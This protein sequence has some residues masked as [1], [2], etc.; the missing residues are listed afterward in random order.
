MFSDVDVTLLSMGG[1]QLRQKLPTT[2]VM[3][4]C[5][6]MLML[7]LAITRLAFFLP[8][9][10]LVKVTLQATIQQLQAQM[11]D[12]EVKPSRILGNARFE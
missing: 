4:F 10:G 2:A 12:T 7:K 3:Q 8:S 5:R 6:L 9:E 11:L 1:A